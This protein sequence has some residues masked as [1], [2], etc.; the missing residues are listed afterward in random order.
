MVNLIS[1]GL[2]SYSL[3]IWITAYLNITPPVDDCGHALLGFLDFYG[4]QFD[5]KRY[6]IDIN[7]GG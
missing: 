3:N 4:N 2:S 7:N 6:G 1:G 5:H